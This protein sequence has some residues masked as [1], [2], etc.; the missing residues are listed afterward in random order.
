MLINVRLPIAHHVI[1]HPDLTGIFT[2]LSCLIVKQIFYICIYIHL[3]T[4]L[5]GH[6]TFLR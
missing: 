2:K 6:F 1:G 5:I 3:T 4:F